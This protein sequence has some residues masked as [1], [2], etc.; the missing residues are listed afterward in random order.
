M[1]EQKYIYTVDPFSQQYEDQTRLYQFYDNLREGKLTTTGCKACGHIPWPPRVI[2][3]Q[4]LSDDLEWVDMP[5]TGKV[6]SYTIQVAAVPPGYDPPLV[7]ALVDFDNGVRIFTR[8]LDT[9]PEEVKTGMEVEL[10]VG[11]A[12]PDAQGRD[13]IIPCFTLKR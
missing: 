11:A 8:L 3:P 1:A 13:R 6:Y 5:K 2:C 4:C 9:E 7:F 12:P 10:K